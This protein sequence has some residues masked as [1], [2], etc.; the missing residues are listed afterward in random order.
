MYLVYESNYGELQCECDA[1]TIIGLY[2]TKEQAIN[3]MKHEVETNKEY[4]FVLDNEDTDIDSSIERG[5]LTMFYKYQ[6]NWNC[7]FEIIIEE[8][9]VSEV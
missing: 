7:Y 2:K 8:I 4:D 9:K 3:V 1:T 6:E 5:R